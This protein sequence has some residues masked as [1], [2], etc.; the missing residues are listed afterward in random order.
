MTTSAV[1]RL[2]AGGFRSS[3]PARDLTGQVLSAQQLT[4]HSA[5]AAQRGVFD[6]AGVSLVVHETLDPEV[7]VLEV[8]HHGRSRVT[9]GDYRLRA[10]DVVRVRDGEIVAYDEYMDPILVARLLGRTDA[11]HEALTPT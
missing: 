2:P 8:E 11:L 7:V 10:L 3:R 1:N 4:F 5:A 6:M 9:G